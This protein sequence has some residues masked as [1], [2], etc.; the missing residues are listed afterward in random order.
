MT[1]AEAVLKKMSNDGIITLALDYQVKFKS[2]LFD[3]D[4]GI[5]G[6]KYNF[7]KPGSE[8]LVSMSVNSNLCKKTQQFWKDSVGLTTI[9][10]DE[11]VWKFRVSLKT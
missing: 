7:E 11:N 8:F 10:V 9:I 1:L 2:T 3:I 6:L 5:G 4:K